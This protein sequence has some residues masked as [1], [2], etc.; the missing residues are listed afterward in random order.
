MHFCLATGEAF[1]SAPVLLS[2]P[3]TIFVERFSETVL[4]CNVIGNPEPF[5]TWY[6]DGLEM[7]GATQKN[8]VIDEVDLLDRA[9][10]QCTAVNNRGNVT[11]DTAYVNIRG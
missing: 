7:I 3:Q 6:K 4:D 8:L 1:L 10:Y 2:P 11:S 9:A 5:I